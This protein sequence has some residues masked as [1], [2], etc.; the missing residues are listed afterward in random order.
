MTP[1]YRVLGAILTER[2]H[3]VPFGCPDGPQITVF[4]GEVSAPDGAARPYLV[5][6]QGGP[7]IE[8]TRPTSPVRLDEAG[9]Q[10]LPRPAPR[11]SAGRA[12]A[13]SGQLRDA[14]ALRPLPPWPR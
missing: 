6:L 1:I 14:P 12:L 8:A 5:F 4:T 13:P 3:S 11:I 2:E 7:D 9:H 10:G